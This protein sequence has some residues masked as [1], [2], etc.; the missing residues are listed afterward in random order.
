ME[1]MERPESRQAKE[2]TERDGSHHEWAALFRHG[3]QRDS[4]GRVANFDGLDLRLLAQLEIKERQR[5]APYTENTVDR[6]N[7]Y[8]YGRGKDVYQ[9][10]SSDGQVYVMQSYSQEVD[11]TQR[12]AFKLW[13]R[14]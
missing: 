10:V 14:A 11:K 13:P 8:I 4:R 7:Q 9:L 12:K 6:Q 3:T 5:R 1:R 2:R